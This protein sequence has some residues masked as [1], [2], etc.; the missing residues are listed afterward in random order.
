MY[1]ECEHDITLRVWSKEEEIDR[2]AEAL[3]LSVE[4]RRSSGPR[5][6][7]IVFKASDRAKGNLETEITSL[8]ELLDS[9]I[10][11]F[12]ENVEAWVVLGIY[13]F[14]LFNLSSETLERLGKM[15]IS[16]SVENSS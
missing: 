6:P 1:P 11:S 12:P 9:K 8:I 16:I 7:C 14:S 3:P 10:C 13:G 15:N 5:G 4:T 2:L